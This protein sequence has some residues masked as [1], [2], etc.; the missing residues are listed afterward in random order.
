MSEIPE[1][2]VRVT[3]YEVSCLPLGHPEYKNFKVIVERHRDGRWSASDGLLALTSGGA[4]VIDPSCVAHRH[5]EEFALQLARAAAPHVTCNG[6]TV[7]DALRDR[8][9]PDA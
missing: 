6:H 3:R 5:S 1:P 2:E 8:E 9:T 4:W 7:A